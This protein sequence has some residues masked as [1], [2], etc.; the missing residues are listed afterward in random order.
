MPA[1]V[2]SG[3][4]A[5]AMV[6]GLLV[7]TM[8][9]NDPYWRLFETPSMPAPA[10]E[11]EAE[12]EAALAS[13]TVDAPHP[14]SAA[15]RPD[16]ADAA[17][18][19]RPPEPP[20]ALLA[21]RPA[22][23]MIAVPAAFAPAADRP[24]AVPAAPGTG[25]ALALAPEPA[26]AG[27]G[28]AVPP[29]PLPLAVTLHIPEADATAAAAE[30]AALAPV[31]VPD[32]PEPLRI[33]ADET[34]EQALAL[35]RAER[36]RIQRRLS[37]AGFDPRGF[38][39]IF[40]PRTR[41]A[42]A[43]FQLASGFPATGYLDGSVLADLSARTDEAYAAYA[44]RAARTARSA[45][46]RAPVAEQRRL[47]EATGSGGCVRDAAGR[48]IPR[49]SLGCDLKGFAEKTVSLGRDR[50]AFEEAGGTTLAGFGPGARR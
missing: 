23:A 16:A 27:A 6:G 37:L 14:D 2:I 30:L 36:V 35:A 18:P 41:Q 45:P 39:G 46:K 33:R 20:L 10:Y 48:I 1:G 42:I 17:R 31:A 28:P 32:A 4:A 8:A 3:V 47:A 19:G 11:T 44:A 26:A 15:V 21:P 13:V 29:A 7:W 24:D 50:L 38:D 25:V 9:A 34:S 22:D 43:D 49:Q 5:T 40:G 12:V